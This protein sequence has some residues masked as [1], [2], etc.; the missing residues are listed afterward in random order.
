VS[1]LLGDKQ[2]A[3]KGSLSELLRS[4]KDKA[5]V[6]L[7]QELAKVTQ[8]RMKSRRDAANL[9]ARDVNTANARF[10]KETANAK[11]AAAAVAA[12]QAAVA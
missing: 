8:D 5:L 7:L 1:S 9:A 6:P 12:A 2:E 3:A 11:S 4:M 10:N